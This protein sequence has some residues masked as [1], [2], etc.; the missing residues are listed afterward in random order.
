MEI[1]SFPKFLP[2]LLWEP[3]EVTDMKALG[4]EAVFFLFTI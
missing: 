1:K 2:K 4:S 3:D